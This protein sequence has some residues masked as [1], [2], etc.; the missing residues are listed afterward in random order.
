MFPVILT[1]KKPAYHITA[2]ARRSGGAAIHRTTKHRKEHWAAFV[3]VAKD[4][5]DE[6][7]IEALGDKLGEMN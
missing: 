6:D 7:E 3:K 1:G 2:R 5:M 4:F